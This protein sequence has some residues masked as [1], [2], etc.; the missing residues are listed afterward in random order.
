[1]IIVLNIKKVLISSAI[2]KYDGHIFN[3]DFKKDGPCLRCFM[4]NIP[5][6]RSKL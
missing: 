4:P 2:S 5:S 6:I 1:M 3:F